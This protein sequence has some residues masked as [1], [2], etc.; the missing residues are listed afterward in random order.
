[1]K[2]RSLYVCVLSVIAAM[3]TLG[4]LPPAEAKTIQLTYSI[5][6]PATNAQ[7]KAGV[8]WAREVEKRSNGQ[9]KITVFPGGT[10]TKANQCYDGVAKGI[11]DIGMSVFAYTR[12]RFPVMEAADLPLGYPDGLTATRTVNAFYEKFKPEELSDVK[13]LSLHAHGPGGLHTRKPVK[14]LEDLKDMKIRSTGLSAKVV[15]ALGAVPVAMPQ[16]ATYESLQKGV[17]E[18]T[19]GPIEVLKGW[20]QAEVIKSTTDCFNVGY[21]T[22]MY[23]VMNQKKWA[24]LPKDVQDVMTAVSREWIDVHG[25]SWDSADAKGREYSFSLGNDIISLSEPES[26]RWTEAVAPIIQEY[27]ANADQKNL[28][29]SDSVAELTRLI[30]EFKG[31]P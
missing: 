11:S 16:G 7:C 21:T 17:V 23:V 15:E 5:F 22:A 27:I 6:F 31:R 8:E 3:L 25:K 18:G 19:F 2:M 20:R 24:Q 13:V 26:A 28:N 1:M 4:V 29:G 12:G 9:V 30:E 10:L 14:T